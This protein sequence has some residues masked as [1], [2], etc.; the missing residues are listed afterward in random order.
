MHGRTK[1]RETVLQA[2]YQMD[3]ADGSER[4]CLDEVCRSRKLAPDTKEYCETLFYGVT[5]HLG[6]I[7]RLIEGC[8]EN[9]TV[10]RMGVIDRNILR[11]AVFELLYRAEVPYKVV[12]DEAVELAKK[13][14]TGESSA[15]INGILDRVAKDSAVRERASVR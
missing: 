5:G 4:E 6:E 1:A 11:M 12:I 15:F 14:G 7:D 9:W 10:D 2:L 13:F 8:S 3:L